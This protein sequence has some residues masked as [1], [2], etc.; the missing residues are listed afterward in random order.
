[1]KKIIVIA[2]FVLIALFTVFAI[3]DNLLSKDTSE[4][5]APTFEV[6]VYQT[7]GSTVQANTEVVVYDANA[8][9]VESGTTLSNGKVS[10]SWNHGYGNYTVKAWYPARPLDGQS[11]QTIVNYSGSS[12]YTSVTLGP[13]Y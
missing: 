1:M 4:N 2:S 6:T 8:N 12:I 3:N 13:N 7:G 5:P 9:I 11:A 10:W